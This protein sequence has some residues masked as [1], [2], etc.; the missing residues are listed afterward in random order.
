M[1]DA[2]KRFPIRQD[3]RRDSALCIA[4]G[5]WLD[6]RQYSFLHVVQTGSGVHLNSYY[7]VT[8]AFSPGLKRSGR[9]TDN[10]SP[11]SAEVKKKW[12]YTSTAP[13]SFMA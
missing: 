4:T 1:I 9:E 3:E 7:M 10:S 13:Y 2:L 11:N 5:Y 6:D 12:I 8:G